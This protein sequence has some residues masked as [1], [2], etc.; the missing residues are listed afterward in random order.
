M[1]MIG[2]EDLG[3]VLEVVLGVDTHL[4]LHV[5]VELSGPTGQTPG[6]TLTV[7]TTTV[8]ATRASSPGRRTSAP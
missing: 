4:D 2:G 5:V 3:I 1:T 8:K 7:P 6:G